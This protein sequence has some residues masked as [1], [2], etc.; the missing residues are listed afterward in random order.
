MALE[1]ENVVDSTSDLSLWFKLLNGEPLTLSDVSEIIRLRWDYF[2][3]NWE[4]IKPDYVATIGQYSNPE[5]FRAQID[6]FSDFIKSQR[7]TSNGNNPFDNDDILLRFYSI[8]DNTQINNIKLTFEE[9]TIV[10]NKTAKIRAFTR[11]DF[12]YI[13]SQIQKERDI[14]ADKTNTTDEDYNRIFNRS[15]QPGRVNINNKDVNKMYELQQSIKTVDFVLANAF[16]L[17]TS[18]IDPFA[19]A[20]TNANNKLDIGDY[21]SGSMIKLNY[22]E[23]LQALSKRTL[24]DPDRWIDIAI[25]NGLKPP[26]IDE[27][28]ERIDLISNAG[29]NQ[30]NLSGTDT[31][32]NLNVNKMSVGQ[33][34]LLQSDIL[35]FPE[36]RSIL[37]ITEVPISGELILELDGE[38]DL[39]K[40]KVSENANIRIYKQNTINS[41]FYI[42]I[43]NQETLDDNNADDK[44]PW[45]L[46]TSDETE[47]RQKIDLK[48]EEGGDLIFDPSGDL[49][50][51]FGLDNSTQAVQL[52]M[53]VEL[54]EL[55]RHP[56]YGLSTVAGTTNISIEDVKNQVAQNIVNSITSDE[57]FSGI[58]RLD[59]EYMKDKGS[60]KAVALSIILIVKLA[61]SDQLVPITFSVSL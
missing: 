44:E 16:A 19:L 1:L 8:F 37:N 50:L 61:D 11:G 48:L 40:Y 21:S 55:R 5:Q 27:I 10:S 60:D 13:R 4:Y 14:I 38:S 30:I 7:V 59:V 41:S 12:L 51:T 15:P 45:F 53:G 33:V 56:E 47:K 34:V 9:Q 23:D 29:G 35:T 46:N 58:N 31:S 22:G 57:R 32:N 52:K 3:D 26:Y 54:G 2:R 36:Q 18:A 6:T 39:N 49:Q 42:L 20:R 43:P 24:G 17:T 25:A 28:G